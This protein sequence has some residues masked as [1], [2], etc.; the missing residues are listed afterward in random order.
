MLLNTSQLPSH[1]GCC[2]QPTF[3]FP[4][5][6]AK[7][8][9]PADEATAATGSAAV[10]FRRHKSMAPSQNGAIAISVPS[11]LTACACHH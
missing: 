5:D 10:P 2:T 7:N 8:E 4:F 6:D 9:R 11:I 1:R 3:T